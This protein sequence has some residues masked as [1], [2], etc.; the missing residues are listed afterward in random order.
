LNSKSTAVTVLSC[1]QK[2]RQGNIYTLPIDIRSKLDSKL[3]HISR[4]RSLI[5]LVVR[6]WSEIALKLATRVLIPIANTILLITRTTT[7]ITLRCKKARCSQEFKIVVVELLG[8][9]DPLKVKSNS[10]R[11]S[12]SA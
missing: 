1:V 11:I 2:A 10:C 3:G 9:T 5:L 12:S 4:A 6:V 7:T 8:Q